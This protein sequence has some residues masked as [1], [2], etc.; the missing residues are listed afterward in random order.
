MKDLIKTETWFLKYMF[1]KQLL[2]TTFYGRIS[3][4]NM[5]SEH[6]LL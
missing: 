6:Q 5:E 1:I 2:A 4:N 3:A